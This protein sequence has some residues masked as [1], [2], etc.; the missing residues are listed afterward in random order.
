MAYKQTVVFVFG[1]IAAV[2]L[3][4]PLN[5]P[6]CGCVCTDNSPFPQQNK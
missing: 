5:V 6:Y 3:R 4:I 1:G 2:L